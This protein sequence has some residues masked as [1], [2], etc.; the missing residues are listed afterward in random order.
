[1][2]ARDRLGSMGLE[3]PQRIRRRREEKSA[4]AA[5]Q[6]QQGRGGISVFGGAR[7]NG[8]EAAAIQRSVGVASQRPR[9]IHIALT[10]HACSVASPPTSTHPNP[11]YSPA[12][13]Q[14]LLAREADP[15]CGRLE[16]RNWLFTIVRRCPRY[17][18]LLNDL[19][20]CTSPDDAEYTQLTAAH[21][22]VAKITLT[23]NTSIHTH[24]QTLSLVALQCATPFF[25]F[26]LIVPG[27]AV[28]RHGPLAHVERSAPP[29]DREFL[30]SDRIV[31]LEVEDED[32]RSPYAP[33]CGSGSGGSGESVLLPTPK[34]VYHH[35][36]SRMKRQRHA[37]SRT[38]KEGQWV[39]K[40][41][42]ELVD[43]E[44]VVT[45]PREVGEERR[46]QVLSPEG[47]FVLYAGTQTRR[48]SV[49]Q[50]K[51][52]L[53]VSLDAMHPDSTL[54]SSSSTTHLRRS[55][56]A[57]PVPPSDERLMTLRQGKGSG[58]GKK[59]ER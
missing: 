41:R 19:I 30:F 42:V 12:F 48:K 56:Q 20:A 22:L 23:L 32:D 29:C 3:R 9:L 44:V 31:W 26:Q 46:F 28:I 35:P 14:Y 10:F 37:S 38:M 55:L 53:F 18:L 58:K 45:P 36:V 1:M 24:A 5:V 54:T 43:L 47:G 39:Y 34:S 2:R 50:N 57:L 11:H 52:Q 15:R 59:L 33:A 16:L 7:T 8:N 51:A 49:T 17:L 13:T 27:R 40:G 4:P 21:A 25:P 6:A